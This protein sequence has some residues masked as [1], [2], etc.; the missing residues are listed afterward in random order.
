MKSLESYDAKICLTSA[1]LLFNHGK[2]LLVKH[3]KLQIWLA[4]GGHMEP[5]EL[6][7]QA[8]EREFWEETGI[9][10]K[11]LSPQVQFSGDAVSAYMPNPVVSNLHWMNKKNYD[12]RKA[13]NEFP[14]GSKAC[15]Q[16]ICFVYLVEAQAGIKYT[17]NIEET[18]GI[19]WFSIPEVQ[20][21]VTTEDIKYEVEYASKLVPPSSSLAD[22]LEV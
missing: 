19:G 2:V 11:A 22:D 3:K 12:L 17:Q 14:V 15:E 5:N 1:G 7:H 20:K 21:L 13:G 10:V 8:A 6:P 9:R 16:H 4:P 18:D